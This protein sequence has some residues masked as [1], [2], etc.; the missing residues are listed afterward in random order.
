MSTATR[1][2]IEALEVRAHEIPTDEPESDGTLEWDSTTIVV[3]RARAGGETGL[4]YTYTDAA[5]AKL[6]EGKLTE[7][8]LGRDAFDVEGA[9]DHAFSADRPVVVDA[10]CDPSVPPLPPHITVKEARAFVSALRKGDPHMRDVI[11]QSFKEKILEF[12]P[13]R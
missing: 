8:V 10:L 6:I 13:G 4:G 2:A 7:A 5:A 12:L 9:W 1:A 11:T 3:V